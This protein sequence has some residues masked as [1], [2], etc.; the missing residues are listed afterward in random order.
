M[1][2]SKT[3]LPG[4]LI[5]EQCIKAHG[6][7]IPEAASRAGVIEEELDGLIAGRIRL[8][9][10]TAV[11]LERA[12]GG[13]AEA[14]CRAQADLDLAEAQAWLDRTQTADGIEDDGESKLWF[15]ADDWKPR[16]WTAE[17]TEAHDHF[18]W[19]LRHCPDCACPRESPR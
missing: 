6:L 14:W 16:Q 19:S 3:V 4:Q 9:A 15:L 2:I 17:E 12:L 8:S 5:L 18:L 10:R 13:S 11:R 7:T 1:T